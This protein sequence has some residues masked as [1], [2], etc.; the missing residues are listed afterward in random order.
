M[1]RKVTHKPT[2]DIKLHHET[3]LSEMQEKFCQLYVCNPTWTQTECAIAAGYSE[4]SAHVT[5]SRFLNG[6]DYPDVIKRI[7]DLKAEL[8]KKYEVTFDNHVQML[9]HIRDEAIRN[10]NYPAA[11][12]AEKSRGQAAG[13]YVE[14]KEIL[15]GKIDQ[16][17]REQVMAEIQKLTLDYPQLMAMAAPEL[18]LSK[19]EYSSLEDD[20]E[21]LA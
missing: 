5:A 3:G 13:L 7:E 20:D 12:S 8:A 16:M 21:S 11:V 10:G 15:H 17:T 1:T 19:K 9:A 14:R 2:L 6:R 4:G 18:T